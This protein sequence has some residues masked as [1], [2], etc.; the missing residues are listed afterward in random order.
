M[1]FSFSMAYSKKNISHKKRCG[2][3]SDF[4]NAL[5]KTIEENK[6]NVL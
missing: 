4:L 3:F 6:S 2:Q 5:M 1:D